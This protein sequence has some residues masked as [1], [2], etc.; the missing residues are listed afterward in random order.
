MSIAERAWQPMELEYVGLVG[1]LMRGATGS[2]QD[3]HNTCVTRK[4][5][6]VG[7][8]TTCP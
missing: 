6:H 4:A 7:V 1:T 8:G 3:S 2:K 5:S